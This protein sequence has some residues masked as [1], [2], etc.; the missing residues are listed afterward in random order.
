MF[1]ELKVCRPD[2]SRGPGTH[3]ILAWW[4]RTLRVQ[5]SGQRS[6]RCRLLG[7]VQHDTSYSGGVMGHSDAT[8]ALHLQPCVWATSAMCL[9]TM[10]THAPLA[11]AAAAAAAAA[12]ACSRLISS[13]KRC[14]I[15]ANAAASGR[16]Q[17]RGPAWQPILCRHADKRP[18]AGQWCILGRHAQALVA[19]G[20]CAVQEVVWGS[21]CYRH[22]HG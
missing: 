5:R 17:P 8:Q 11:P 19:A 2:E 10:P 1:S 13:S 20:R 9:V 16:T 6:A 22:R 4:R 21:V 14:S 15:A 18:A 7:P 3:G 12:A